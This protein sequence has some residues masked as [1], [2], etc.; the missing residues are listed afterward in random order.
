MRFWEVFHYS[1]ILIATCIIIYS[2]IY[3]YILYNLR[4]CNYYGFISDKMYDEVRNS[5]TFYKKAIYIITNCK[6][7]T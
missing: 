2:Y 6:Y 1:F 4:M 7:L 5:K 3:L